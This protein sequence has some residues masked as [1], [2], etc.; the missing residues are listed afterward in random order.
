MYQGTLV[1]QT[2]PIIPCFIRA[3]IT[4][5][6]AEQEPVPP[7]QSKLG[8]SHDEHLHGQDLCGR[9]GHVYAVV[10]RLQ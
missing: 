1:H 7:E 10:H 8:V 3:Y 6:G 9:S 5:G 2:I 4:S